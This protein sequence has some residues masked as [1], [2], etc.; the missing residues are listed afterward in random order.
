MTQEKI[1]SCY[2]RQVKRNCPFSFRKRLIADLRSH[3]IDYFDDNPCN[4]FEDITNHLGPPEK[5]A[6]EYLL[7]IDEITRKKALQKARWTKRSV[8]AGISA[9]VLIIAVTAVWMLVEISQKRVYHSYEY[10]TQDNIEN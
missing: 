3:L 10:I 8:L 4:T 2:L 9:I 7:V 1:I 5:F 6:D